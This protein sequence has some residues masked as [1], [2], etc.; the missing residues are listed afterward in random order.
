[1]LPYYRWIMICIK[2]KHEQIVPLALK[3]ITEQGRLKFIRPIYRALHDWE[4]ARPEAI[5]TLVMNQS[6]MMRN[7]VNII[8]KDLGL[9]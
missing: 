6:S 5:A 4:H 2:E 1:M 7:S 3:F 8:R 9:I